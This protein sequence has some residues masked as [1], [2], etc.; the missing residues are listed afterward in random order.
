MIVSY[1]SARNPNELVT[2]RAVRV[3]NGGESFQT[4]GDALTV[5]D[6]T[7][8]GSLLTGRV[9]AVLPGMGK[10]LDW[11]HSWPGLVI[12]VYLPVTAITFQELYR[13][14]RHYFRSRLYQL[15]GHQVV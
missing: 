3:I 8:R 1:K 10:L 7:V 15:R 6:P 5:A 11:L 2:H 12:C 9:V 13:L 4:K 14:E